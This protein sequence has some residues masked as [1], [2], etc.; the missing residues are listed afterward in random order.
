MIMKTMNVLNSATEKWMGRG[1]G[2]NFIFQTLPLQ[3]FYP[4]RLDSYLMD[5]NVCKFS[6]CKLSRFPLFFPSPE[7][8]Q[9][10]ENPDRPQVIENQDGPQVI[11]NQFSGPR[12]TSFV[13]RISIA[14]FTLQHDKQIIN[15]NQEWSQT[16][17]RGLCSGTGIHIE[18]N[19]LET[20]VLK[21]LASLGANSL[22]PPTSSFNLTSCTHR[23]W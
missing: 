18:F 7:L 5:V 1:F 20:F 6:F 9:I 3:R 17:V 2:V 15:K 4:Y 13:Q 12:S 23:I 8:N 21:S 10:R 11:G 14:C 16:K 19:F 22:W